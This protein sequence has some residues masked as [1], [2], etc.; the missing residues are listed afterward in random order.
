MSEEG[1]GEGK[2]EKTAIEYFAVFLRRETK[3]KYKIECPFAFARLSALLMCVKV[4]DSECVVQF[5]DKN[6][7]KKR[8]QKL[9]KKA[10]K[11]PL[12]LVN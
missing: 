9:K 11:P 12:Q 2:E 8:K 3:E 7:N 4:G 6:E 10:I 1:G 5:F